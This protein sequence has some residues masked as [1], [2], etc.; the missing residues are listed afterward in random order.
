MCIMKTVLIYEFLTKLSLIPCKFCSFKVSSG[1]NSSIGFV[2]VLIFHIDTKYIIYLRILIF[3]TKKR[4]VKFRH[5]TRNIS[6]SGSK[7]RPGCLN[8]KSFVNV[9]LKLL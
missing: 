7:G 4:G 5:S 2:N 3:Y 1:Q 9:V 8:T 6:N